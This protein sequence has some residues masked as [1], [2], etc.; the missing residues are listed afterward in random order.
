M[1]IIHYLKMFK[2]KHKEMD[3]NLYFS[4][5]SVQSQKKKK[6]LIKRHKLKELVL[7]AF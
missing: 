7:L 1:L 4:R 6:Y 2:N 5:K 3:R